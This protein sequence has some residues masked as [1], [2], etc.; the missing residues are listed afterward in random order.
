MKSGDFRHL[1]ERAMTLLVG[2]QSHKAASLFFIQNR[3][4]SVDHGMFLR[5]YA[6]R[7]G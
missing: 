3:K 7:F 1:F 5:N 4:Q 6:E 2:E